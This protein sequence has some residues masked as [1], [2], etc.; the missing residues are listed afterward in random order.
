[1]S[2]FELSSEGNEE[3]PGVRSAA[4]CRNLC[5]GSSFFECRSATY[6]P[7]SGLCK[8]SEETRRSA[9][10]DYRPAGRTVQ[11]MENECSDSEC[12]IISSLKKHGQQQQ[13]KNF[14][15][16]AITKID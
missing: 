8:L 16:S 6:Y 3:I 15:Y 4:E 12:K 9:P 2:G 5:L 10:Q 1:M 7:A 11:Y 14:T 13:H